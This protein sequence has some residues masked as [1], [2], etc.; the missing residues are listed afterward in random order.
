MSAQPV[1]STTPHEVVCILSNICYY[2]SKQGNALN[3]E[4]KKKKKSTKSEPIPR[5]M[6]K[7]Y[8]E[9]HICIYVSLSSLSLGCTMW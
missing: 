2:Q 8:R 7:M 3:I 6:V 9:R 1:L 4:I 5:T